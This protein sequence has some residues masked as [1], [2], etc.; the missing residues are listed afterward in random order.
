[1]SLPLMRP[2]KLQR[3]YFRFGEPIRTDQY[4]GDF[5]PGEKNVKRVR[6][7]AERAMREN[8]DFLFR[9]RREDPERFAN[10]EATRDNA[11][12]LADFVRGRRWGGDRSDGSDGKGGDGGG[13]DALRSESRFS[14]LSLAGGGEGGGDDDDE[15]EEHGERGRKGDR[16]GDSGDGE[17]EDDDDDDDDEGDDSVWGV[18]T[19]PFEDDGG[20]GSKL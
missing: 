11:R 5:G 14:T 18:P 2:G 12:A 1:M 17:E 7:L 3:C 8:L 15:E 6:S 16:S 13:R 19:S 4:R 9:F 20:A 10:L